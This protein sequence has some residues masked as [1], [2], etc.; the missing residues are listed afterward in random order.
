MDQL[1]AKSEFSHF[2][3]VAIALESLGNPAAA[4]PLARL[5]QKPDVSGHAFDDINTALKNTPSSGT[6]TSLRNRALSELVLARALYRCG[7]YEGLGQKIL[8]QYAGDL[9]GLYARHAQAILA[10]RADKQ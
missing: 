5:L 6:D 10:Q 9:H 8:R 7:D 3:A 1:D 4:Q 2:R